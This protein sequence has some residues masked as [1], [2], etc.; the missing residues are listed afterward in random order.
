[1]YDEMCPEQYTNPDELPLL[2][3]YL[4][5]QSQGD[6]KFFEF[7]GL[8]RNATCNDFRRHYDKDGKPDIDRAAEDLFNYPPIAARIKEVEAEMAEKSKKTKTN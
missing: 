8:P 4:E 7:I 5:Y 2:G 1:M 6:G 3:W